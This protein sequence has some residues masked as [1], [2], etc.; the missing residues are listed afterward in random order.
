[1][2]NEVSVKYPLIAKLARLA[3]SHTLEELLRIKGI[4]SVLRPDVHSLFLR[5]FFE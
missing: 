4:P 2:D 3:E 1:M 5:Y